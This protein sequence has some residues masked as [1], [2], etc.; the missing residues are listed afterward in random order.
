MFGSDKKWG[1]Y[2][3]NVCSIVFTA[4]PPVSRLHLWKVS[5]ADHMIVVGGAVN[6]TSLCVRYKW[7]TSEMMSPWFHLLFIHFCVIFNR[8]HF[9]VVFF[10][11]IGVWLFSTQYLMG[12]MYLTLLTL[13]KHSG[14]WESSLFVLHTRMNSNLRLFHLR[15]L[16]SVAFLHDI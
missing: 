5:V 2:Y 1:L 15:V 3:Y 8:L 16:E 7:C 13:S 6:Y 10:G 4:P 14:Q 12:A 9:F 11:E